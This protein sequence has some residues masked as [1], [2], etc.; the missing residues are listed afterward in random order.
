MPHSHHKI[1]IDKI[2]SFKK[3]DAE[4]RKKIKE[5]GESTVSDIENSLKLNVRAQK[6]QD[7]DQAKRLKMMR[8]SELNIQKNLL[9]IYQTIEKFEKN[10]VIKL[11]DFKNLTTQTREKTINSTQD[12]IRD[13]ECSLSHLNIDIDIDLSHDEENN[14]AQDLDLDLDPDSDSDSDS[15]PK[16][17]NT[18]YVGK[19]KEYYLLELLGAYRTQHSNLKEID[20][21]KR[22]G[23]LHSTLQTLITENADD[24]P[25][26]LFKKVRNAFKQSL[27]ILGIKVTEKSLT[28]N[29]SKK[30][31]PNTQ[32]TPELQLRDLEDL[33]EKINKIEK[34][35]EKELKK[36]I[37]TFVQTH[38]LSQNTKTRACL[39]LLLGAVLSFA[40]ALLVPSAMEVSFTLIDAGI[41]AGIGA[42][43]GGAAG[44]FYPGASTEAGQIRDL[45]L[46][47]PEQPKQAAS[48]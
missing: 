41:V 6:N 30:L 42:A 13:T 18:F 1:F 17:I 23:E 26:G 33:A 44:F 22:I 15:D 5:E 43:L 21:I 37:K 35:D 3:A 34:N 19:I 11:A 38:N 46:H 10:I 36:V 25:N 20:K 45:L 24:T 12:E 39:G 29:N 32:L 14:P 8:I 7:Q 40:V 31:E 28:H 9:D 4:Q 2:R 47:P 48:L 27:N 16:S